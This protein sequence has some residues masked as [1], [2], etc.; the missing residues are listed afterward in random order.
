MNS[1]TLIADLSTIVCVCVCWML[2][3]SVFMFSLFWWAL[4]LLMSTFVSYSL[5]LFSATVD[6]IFRISTHACAKWCKSYLITLNLR[7][8]QCETL[9]WRKLTCP[10]NCLPVERESYSPHSSTDNSLRKTNS[11]L[12]DSVRSAMRL[13]SQKLISSRVR[14]S[15]IKVRNLHISWKDYLWQCWTF[16]PYSREYSCCSLRVRFASAACAASSGPATTC[17]DPKKKVVYVKV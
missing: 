6:W 3:H 16:F 4:N 17:G 1:H 10:A 8:R 13:C 15:R 12:T 9:E 11:W 2:P 5:K 7:I 14:K